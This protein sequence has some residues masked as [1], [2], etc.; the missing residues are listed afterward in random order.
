MELRDILEVYACPPHVAA[1]RKAAFAAVLEH[2]DQLARH[3]ASMLSARGLLAARQAEDLVFDQHPDYPTAR[4]GCAHHGHDG[5]RHHPPDTRPVLPRLR[6][7]VSP[8]RRLRPPTRGVLHLSQWSSASTRRLSPPRGS[9]RLHQLSK[10]W[11]E[12]RE[13]WGR[14]GDQLWGEFANDDADLWRKASADKGLEKS[15]SYCFEQPAKP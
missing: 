7:V 15:T 10:R 2:P 14:T 12:S 9:K 13:T 5:N 3:S 11:A 8:R 4:A 6:Q 1:P